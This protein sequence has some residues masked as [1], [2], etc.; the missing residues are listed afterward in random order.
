MYKYEM[1]GRGRKT[2]KRNN[3]ARLELF[4]RLA[5]EFATSA[6]AKNGLSYELGQSW[7]KQEPQ[8]K[9]NLSQPNETNLKAALMDLRKFVQQEEDVHVQ[10]I[11]NLVMRALARDGDT[12]TA[13]QMRAD[14]GTMN[15]QWKT[16]YQRGFMRVVIDG[17]DYSPEIAMNLW[18]NGRYFHDDEDYAQKLDKLQQ[19]NPVAAMLVRAQFLDAVLA[20]AN[21]VTWLA[22]NVDY[23][24]LRDLLDLDVLASA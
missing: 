19:L 12:R 15:K 6:V 8:L 10:R 2:S 22:K 24:L 20:T 17:E 14:L 3:R 13:E 7:S 16:M 5:R 11:H 1:S 21:Y 4:V 9:T 23:F 18:L